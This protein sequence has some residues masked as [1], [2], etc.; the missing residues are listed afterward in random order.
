MFRQQHKHLTERE[1]N[2]GHGIKERGCQATVNGVGKAAPT[3]GRGLGCVGVEARADV[4]AAAMYDIDSFHGD[5]A[6]VC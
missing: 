4:W 5:S 2:R 6:D 1:K 3:L